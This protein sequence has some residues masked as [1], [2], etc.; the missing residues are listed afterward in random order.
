MEVLSLEVKA[1]RELKAAIDADGPSGA[2][3]VE[4]KAL[5]ID[6]ASCVEVLSLEVKATRELKA[7]IDADGPSGAVSVEVKALLIAQAVL[8]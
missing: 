1:T 2:V 6:S 8:K 7:A 5:L 3:S 4:V